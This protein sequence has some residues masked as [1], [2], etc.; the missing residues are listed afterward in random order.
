M[1]FRIRDRVRLRRMRAALRKT[2][3]EDEVRIRKAEADGLRGN[4]LADYKQQLWSENRIVEDEISQLQ[5]RLLCLKASRYGVP[6]PSYADKEMW[7]ESAN[8]GGWHLTTKGYATLRAD[9][10]KE[11]NELWQFWELRTKVIVALATALTGLFGALI[12]WAAFWNKPPT[13]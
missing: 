3:R 12:G 8:I 13:P 5:S 9:I 4:A 7:E 2:Y 11:R 6:V 1:F 10:R